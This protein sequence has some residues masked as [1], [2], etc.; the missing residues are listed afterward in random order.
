MFKITI[1]QSNGFF[2]GFDAYDHADYAEE[3]SDIVCAAAS[4]LVTVTMNA[5]EQFTDLSFQQD[6]DTDQARIVFRITDFPNEKSELL[7]KT[8]VLGM[9]SLEENYE[10]HVDLI[11]EEV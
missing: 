2:I 5:I 3:G 11:F 10:K 6:I 9:E 7:L 4:M 1:F 8:L